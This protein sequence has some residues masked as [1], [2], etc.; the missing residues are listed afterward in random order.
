MSAPAA[1]APEVEEEKISWMGSVLNLPA[2][3]SIVRQGIPA[4]RDFVEI[5][6][7]LEKASHEQGIK[8]AKYSQLQNF[9][10]QLA[11]SYVS[12]VETIK[13]LTST[14]QEYHNIFQTISKQ[15][16]LLQRDVDDSYGMTSKDIAHV[17]A[18][19]QDTIFNTIE[20]VRNNVGKLRDPMQENDMQAAWQAL[21]SISKDMVV[22]HTLAKDVYRQ[23]SA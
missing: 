22:T 17:A 14:M 4:K 20:E 10:K 8:R 11:E 9:N 16:L 1:T 19:T 5:R 15:M 13:L 2:H 21:D 3:S 23:I 12:Q 6:M 7:Q 18:L